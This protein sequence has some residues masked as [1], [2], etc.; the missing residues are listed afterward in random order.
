[1]SWTHDYKVKLEAAPATV[2]TALTTGS[3]LTVWFAEHA[4]PGAATGE[5]FAFWGRHSLE[6]PTQ[7]QATQR[8]IAFDAGRRLGFSWA[9]H[10]VKTTVNIALTEEG[11]GCQLALRHEIHGSLPASRER[12]L[13]DDHWR[14][15]FGNLAA[16]LAGGAGITLPD[17][18]DRS[19]SV[20]QQ[21]VIETTPARVFAALT[22]PA[23]VNQWFGSKG[24]EIEPKAGGKYALNWQ[25]K[26][27]GRDVV[28]G[29]TT[30]LEYVD[31]ERLVLDWPDWRGDA[32]VKG[33][34]IAFSLEPHGEHT[35][36]HF[37]HAGFGRPTDISDFPFGWNWF[38]SELRKVA[39]AQ[40]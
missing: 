40:A 6:T 14:L 34:T 13:I 32:T 5:N 20:Q 7:T 18:T 28:G 37:V 22:T 39:T 11:D 12:E 17:F 31:G 9:I 33:Q 36:L 27:D 10:G 8:I 3:A 30:I 1:M 23:L 35:R 25:Y 29:P 15:A 24:A 21:V 19:P 4:Q 38:L 2:F 16:Y 26:V